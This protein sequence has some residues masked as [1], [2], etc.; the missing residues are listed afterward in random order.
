MGARVQ[1]A[2]LAGTFLLLGIGAAASASPAPG[3]RK[4]TLA[5]QRESRRAASVPGGQLRR[6]AVGPA[7]ATLFGSGAVQHLVVTGETVDGRLVDITPAARITTDAPQLV[8]L[9][10]AEGPSGLPRVRALRDGVVRL[11]ARVGELRAET[12]LTVRGTG[13]ERPLSFANDVLP[14]LTKAGCNNGMCHGKAS[15]QNGFRLSLL[16]FDPEGDYA[17]LLREAG[18][19]RVQRS[20]PEASLLLRKAVG[21]A[22][23]GG[24]VRFGVRSAQ[25]RMLLRWIAEGA[26]WGRGDEPKVTALRVEPEARVMGLRS[27]QQVL[28]TAVYS[29]GTTR[30]VTGDADYAS[31][32]DAVA[33]VSPEG[34]AQTR[35]AAGEAAIMARYMGRVAVTRLTA[36]LAH[37][38]P[39]QNALPVYHPLDALVDARLRTLNIQAGEPTTDAVYLRRVY[40]DVI[41]TLPTV[42]EARAFL[43]DTGAGKR[44]R[45]V[46]QLLERAEYADFWALKWADLLRNNSRIVSERGA[47]VFHAWIR[48][49]FAQNQPYDQFVREVLTASGPGYE[50]GAVNFYRVTNEALDAPAELTNAVTQVF[51]GTRME[52]AQCHHHPYERWSQEDFYGIAA[53]FGRLEKQRDKNGDIAYVTG[54]RNSVTHPRTKQGVLPRV[55]DGPEIPAVAD[56]D[57]RGALATWLTAKD[58]PYL[59]RA[60]ANRMW[61]H[62][63]GRGIVEP[64]DDL[65]LTNPPS[66]PELLDAL[67]R[68]LTT[69]EFDLK[70]L[71]RIICSS[72]VYQTTSTTT[73][74]NRDDT[75]NFSHVVPRRLSAEVLLDAISQVTGVPE[76][77]EKMRA[78]ARAI[79][80][81]NNHTRSYFLD[82]FGRPLRVNPCECE[83]SQEG[84]IAQ[85]LHLLNDPGIQSKLSDPG[86]VVARLL[87]SEAT[88]DVLMTEFYLAALSRPPDLEERRR[89]GEYL[90]R[91]ADRRS[92]VEDLLWAIL[93]TREFLFNH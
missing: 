10:S 85:A 79:Q 33:E 86:G 42:S 11:A 69:H 23:H 45:L 84:N 21:A 36:P 8:Q 77:F 63:L 13:H 3:R 20:A 2:L 43:A 89:A 64:V 9:A 29:D 12:L 7:R 22:P 46:D 40:L 37:R 67:A 50:N 48:S 27:R 31:N 4:Q 72:R 44:A 24:G 65:R 14:L 81:W 34:L 88:D 55:L 71:I 60:I 92:A 6:I 16:G 38:L 66:N 49:R 32:D 75:R 90:A 56:A 73:P 47:E 25:Y 41:G 80:V 19:R 70:H 91:V 57:P 62:F 5:P 58:N 17:A 30:D 78:G 93:N 39:R 28:V 18:A 1:A 87:K 76:S 83:R 74:L 26:P 54:T 52:C 35:G 59:A 51:L 68:E 53:F 15:G 61:A 82:T